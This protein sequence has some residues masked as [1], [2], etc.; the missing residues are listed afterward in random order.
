MVV[1]TAEAITV[2]AV[3]A[4][5]VEVAMVVVAMVVVVVVVMENN[6]YYD[7]S[8]SG[9]NVYK[10]DVRD[11]KGDNKNDDGTRKTTREKIEGRAQIDGDGAKWRKSYIEV[12]IILSWDDLSHLANEQQQ[13]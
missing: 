7:S 8:G 3:V 11:E 4:V 2:M 10:N 12:A 13:Q 1:A 6:G 5:V 9:D